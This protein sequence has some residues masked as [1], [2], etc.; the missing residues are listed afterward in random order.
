MMESDL[1]YYARRASEEARAAARSV[2]PAARA[3]RLM[4]AAQFSRRLA[5][6]GG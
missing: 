2:T 6:L 3:R 5:E 4:L 1:R